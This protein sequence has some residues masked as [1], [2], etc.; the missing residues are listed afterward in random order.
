MGGHT[1]GP[2]KHCRLG[3]GSGRIIREAI[4][5]ADGIVCTLPNAKPLLI[6]EANARLIAAAPRM[7]AVIETMLSIL[8]DYNALNQRTNDMRDDARAIL[9]EIEGA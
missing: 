8:G 6:R 4:D 5:S 2:W 9:R 1:P 7:R 3:S